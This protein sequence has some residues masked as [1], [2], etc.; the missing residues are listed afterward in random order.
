MLLLVSLLF[1]CCEVLAV[2][3]CTDLAVDSVRRSPRPVKEHTDMPQ[4]GDP[5][6]PKI[7]R[8]V[9]GFRVQVFTGGNDRASKRAAMQMSV[10]VQ[11]AFP[12]LSTYVH[13]ESPRWICRVGDFVSRNEAL[14]YARRI[15]QKRL[16]AE[17]AV[18]ACSVLRLQ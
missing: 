8:R 5:L 6:L 11:R 9:P 1:S 18:V 3:L 4:E 2:P 12:E 16:S 14:R 13:F 15:R 10:A 17:A 7:R